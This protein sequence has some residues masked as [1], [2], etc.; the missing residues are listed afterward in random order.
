MRREVFDQQPLGG[1]DVGI[2]DLIARDPLCL[3]DG[4]EQRRPLVQRDHAK[5]AIRVSQARDA[6][7]LSDRSHCFV[8]MKARHSLMEG[9]PFAAAGVGAFQRGRR[10][11]KRHGILHV[12]AGAD[13]ERIGAVEDVARARGVDDGD[14]IGG[15]PLQAGRSRTSSP[16]RS[17]RVT[18][19]TRQLKRASV[20][21]CIFRRAGKGGERGLGEDGVI[22]ERQQPLEHLGIGHVAVEHGRN[23]ARTRLPNNADGAFDPARIGQHR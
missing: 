17:P 3:R 6:A 22:G 1:G 16:L 2:F 11:R 10:R 15:P 18:A 14:G 19:M 12:E 23:A 8:L 13:R 7:V 21:R 4:I 9:I 5:M 20:Q